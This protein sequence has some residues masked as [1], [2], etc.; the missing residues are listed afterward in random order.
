MRD[1]VS[2]VSFSLAMGGGMAI[3]GESG[4]GKT[5][6][7]LA[8]MGLLP[9]EA[10]V[11]RGA[12]EYNGVDLLK[13]NP[14]EWRRR[15]GSGLAL[16]FQE[17]GKALDPLMRV[18]DQ[19]AEAVRAHSRV[20]YREARRRTFAA[21]ADVALPDPSYTARL[22]PH[23]LSGGLQ[24]RVVIAMAL[25]G[26]PSLLVADEP[27]TALDVTVQRQI[28]E[29]LIKLRHERELALLFVTHDLSLV[30]FVAEQVLVMR[31]GAII[32]SGP[33]DQVLKNPQASYTRALIAASPYL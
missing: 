21:M 17:P 9:P 18:G 30:G 2:A 22:Y 4:S 14:Q 20:S 26:K 16:I 8:I 6:L 27:T 23:Q 5:T 31:A 24:Q 1:A 29:L 7:A 15:R 25:V 33:I 13:L 12:I 19:I 32:E 11:L 3:V 10:S 28:I